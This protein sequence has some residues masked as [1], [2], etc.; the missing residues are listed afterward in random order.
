MLGTRAGDKFG[1]ED[2]K[3]MELADR[4][5]REDIEKGIRLN[6]QTKTGTS[7]V[8]TGD[9]EMELPSLGYRAGIMATLACF[10]GNV[11]VLEAIALETITEGRP[12]KWIERLGLMD[13]PLPHSMGRSLYIIWDTVDTFAHPMLSI[14][15]RLSI[16]DRDTG[17]GA[18]WT[19]WEETLG[20][21]RLS[22][23]F[24]RGKGT[25]RGGKDHPRNGMGTIGELEAE[26]DQS[27]LESAQWG[28]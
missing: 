16:M 4:Q 3:R 18:G 14:E 5:I 19:P 1:T 9:Q 27:L 25:D 20:E 7:Q 22:P 24:S 13:G 12:R 17:E 26:D 8:R 21:T 28:H 2:L 6:Q 10:R 23:P 11:A 15:E